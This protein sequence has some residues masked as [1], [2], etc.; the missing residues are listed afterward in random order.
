MRNNVS[1]SAQQLAFDG[2]EIL[3]SETAFGDDN[4]LAMV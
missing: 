3:L 4:K 1:A 2:L